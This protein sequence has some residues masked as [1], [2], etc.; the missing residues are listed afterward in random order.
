[1]RCDRSLVLVEISV[2]ALPTSR[3]ESA[4]AWIVSCSRPIA[5]LKSSLICR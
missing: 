5:T 1:M 2:A 4:T 3:V